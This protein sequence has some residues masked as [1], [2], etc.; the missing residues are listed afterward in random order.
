MKHNGFHDAVDKMIADPEFQ[1]D[2]DKQQEMLSKLQSKIKK[3]GMPE[4]MLEALAK[5]RS[6]FP[7]DTPIR[8]RS[9]T[10][11]EDLPGFSGA[12]LY[13]SFTHAPEEGHLADSVKQV[14]AS[15]WN[16]RALKSG[17]STALITSRRRWGFCCTQLCR[18]DWQERL[19]GTP[20]TFFMKPATTTT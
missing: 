16:F 6:S 12:G 5:I 1:N 14:Y 11:N 2:R 19:G 4:W 10:N 8:C 17:S 3:G 20:M 15:L 9:S 13:D 18:R 7:A